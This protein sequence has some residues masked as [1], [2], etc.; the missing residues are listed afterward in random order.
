MRVEP[1]IFPDYAAS[2]K[3]AFEEEI[4]GETFFAAMA[5]AFDGIP[6]DALNL[7]AQMEAE[8]VRLL[9]PV[10]EHA[11]ISIADRTALRAEGR[12]EGL[13]TAGQGWPE[14]V[15]AMDEE[16]GA[17]VEEFEWMFGQAP[18]K[19]RTRLQ[20]LVD[21]EVAILGFARAWRAGDPDCLA[22]LHRYLARAAAV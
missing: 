21:H 3:V 17:Y 20:F 18:E 9:E 2:L 14:I 15:R 1:R 8:T 12:S 6:A 5:E 16:Y 11:G 19:G 10:V 22:P 7:M 4:S 13:E